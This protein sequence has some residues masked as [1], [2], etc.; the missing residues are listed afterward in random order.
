M[1]LLLM[2]MMMMRWEEN[3]CITRPSNRDTVYWG[4][5]P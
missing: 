4:I 1:K 2:K 5:V 3:Q